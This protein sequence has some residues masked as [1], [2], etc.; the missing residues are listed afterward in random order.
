[1]KPR[2]GAESAISA[3]LSTTEVQPEVPQEAASEAVLGECG[4]APL[5][6]SP[7]QNLESEPQEDASEVESEAIVA[8]LP[9]LD[10][11][12]AVPQEAFD[13]L[14]ALVKQSEKATG[15]EE[16]QFTVKPIPGREFS[17]F[18]G[19]TEEQLAR[20]VYYEGK[21][22]PEVDKVTLFQKNLDGQYV[23]M[24]GMP[25]GYYVK[26][27]Y[28]KFDAISSTIQF[29]QP[30]IMGQE[31]V[32][33]VDK[34]YVHLTENGAIKL[35]E[36]PNGE[37]RATVRVAEGYIEGIKAQAEADNQSLEDWLTAQLQE[38]LEQ[39]FFAAGSR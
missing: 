20:S 28:V 12:P 7:V 34:T 26:G 10:P 21:E 25:S 19:P 11:I 24:P 23:E 9:L 35:G 4:G 30:E 27:Y 37:Y 16:V 15:V 33:A 8:R 2:E 5:E 6:L 36:L 22:Q 38:R 31:H 13:T 1:M 39:W 14:A 3:D 29:R 32:P 17:N 18:G